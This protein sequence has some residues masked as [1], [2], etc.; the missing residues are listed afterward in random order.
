MIG[1]QVQIRPARKNHTAEPFSEPFLGSR[2][3]SV[4]VSS[5]ALP[6]ASGASP[7]HSRMVWI[8]RKSLLFPA[9]AQ[10]RVCACA[11]PLTNKATPKT[12][13]KDLIGNLMHEWI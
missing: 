8:P 7:G 5:Q 11:V 3:V 2:M 13:K 4:G 12:A 1:R 6:L 9:T 10:G